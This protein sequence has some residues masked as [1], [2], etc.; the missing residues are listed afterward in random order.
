MSEPTAKRRRRAPAAQSRWEGV[1]PI[2][3]SLKGYQRED[4]LHDLVAGIVVG[5]V[6]IPQA[7]AYAFLA[8]LPA[9]AGLYSCMVPMV[10]YALM[11]SGRDVMVGPVAVAAIM[12]SS[13]VSQYADPQS[14]RYLAITAVLAFEVGVLL[15]LLKW[16]RMSGMVNLLS[17]PVIVGFVNGAAVLIILGQLEP[18][19]GM[20]GPGDTGPFAEALYIV[21]HLGETNRAT[22]SLALLALALMLCVR[23]FSVPLLRRVFS[24]LT[25]SHPVNR[26]GPMIA[27]IAGT[28]L[29]AAFSL[30]RTYG[31]AVVGQVPAG[32][33]PLMWP[34]IEL[35]LWLELLPKAAMIGLVSFVAT[36]SIGA[37]LGARRRTRVNP[38]QEL[39][40]L[41]G[42]NIGAALTG[43][44]P[45]AG[46]F[47]RSGLNFDAAAR[48]NVSAL[49]CFLMIA[50]TLLWLTPLLHYLPHAVLGVIIIASVLTLL[51]FASV[52]RQW[53]FNRRD[54]VINMCTLIAVL[55]FGIEVGLVIGIL[56]S[57]ALLI[58]RSSQPHIA[59]VGR[60]GGSEQFRNIE[61]YDVETSPRAV[62]IRVDGS[63]YF[64]NARHIENFLMQVANER[65]EIEH[66]VLVCTSINFVDSSG[67]EM[68]DRVT[69]N[70]AAI[71]VS[72]HLADVKGP[73]MDQL[74]KTDF[75]G[76]LSGRV[77]FTTDQ[78]MRDLQQPSA[79]NV[80]AEQ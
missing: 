79:Q 3:T 8:G 63:L 59:V 35:A 56:I 38:D 22:L 73:V 19:L 12:V 80:E 20:A 52:P 16:L 64:A 71:G 11:T 4:F 45:V 23:R 13:A 78:A 36:Y 17:S 49:V 21:T 27:A 10:I 72:V 48:T 75:I 67:L 18:V 28:A 44:Y 6:T 32:L 37:T 14:A 68:L 58:H 41:G 1:F 70:L 65:P 26:V 69:R 61:R 53:S 47:A 40:A 74:A 24:S 50:V 33:P 7:I 55:A 25:D 42:A 31:V 34:D 51:D 5:I 77:Y 30:D 76:R 15:M 39:L 46:S 43:A 66:V 29:V 2:L 54:A 57:V 9:E 60:I 62:A